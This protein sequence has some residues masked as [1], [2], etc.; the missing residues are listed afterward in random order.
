MFNGIIYDFESIKA[1][2]PTGMTL[3]LEKIDYKDKK[4]DEVITG[5]NSVPIG[6]GRGEYS[7]TCDVELGRDE[8]DALDEY[9]SSHGGFYNLP[10][11][12]IVVNYGH[13]GQRPITDTL[14][15]KFNEREL[16]GSKGDKNLR[17]SLKGA[18]TAPLLTNGRPAYVP[19]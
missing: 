19:S 17:V 11:I 14:Q 12:P 9:A 3:T 16:G 15:V 10:P 7:G 8:F 4:E 6:I 18:L 5:T 2:L 13:V 1:L